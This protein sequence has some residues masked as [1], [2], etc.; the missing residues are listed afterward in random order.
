MK[1]IKCVESA[2]YVSDIN[3]DENPIIASRDSCHANYLY[4]L[5]D[6]NETFDMGKESVCNV[7]HVNCQGNSSQGSRD[8]TKKYF[9]F[10]VKFAKL[11]PSPNYAFDMCKLCPW[12]EKYVLFR[13]FRNGGWKYRRKYIFFYF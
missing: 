12:D 2:P 1:V 11:L 13:E 10:Y 5:E 6:R 3:F 4:L 9:V 8:K 7:P